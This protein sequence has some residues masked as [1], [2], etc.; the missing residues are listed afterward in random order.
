MGKQDPATALMSPAA[1]EIV[2]GRALDVHVCTSLSFSH[3]MPP[4]TMVS[5][6]DF[7]R[8]GLICPLVPGSE[9]Q[10]EKVDP[11][12]AGVETSR[13][14]SHWNSNPDIKHYIKKMDK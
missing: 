1:M 12:I 7:T 6:M 10:P 8:D 13:A 11:P 5:L 9:V 3:G 4:A 2:H 14:A